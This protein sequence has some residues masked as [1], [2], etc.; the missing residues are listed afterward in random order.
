MP[1]YADDGYISIV[2]VDASRLMPLAQL[3]P[4][5]LV[6][7]CHPANIGL[8]Q[9]AARRAGFGIAI[10]A[11]KDHRWGVYALDVTVDPQRLFDAFMR[12]QVAGYRR[13]RA[14]RRN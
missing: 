2:M 5:G 11:T 9:R 13:H 1:H 14:R 6:C 12:L 10:R 4:R 7:H 8:M 3:Y